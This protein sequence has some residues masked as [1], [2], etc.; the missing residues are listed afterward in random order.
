M[1][2]FL[3]SFVGANSPVLAAAASQGLHQASSHLQQLQAH[4]LRT[5]P[6]LSPQNSF[7]HAASYLPPPVALFGAAAQAAAAATS[8]SANKSDQ[9]PAKEDNNVVSSTMEEL[10]AQ[11]TNA[12][13]KEKRKGKNKGKNSIPVQEAATSSSTGFDRDDFEE[14]KDFFET[15]CHWENCDKGDFGSQDALVKVSTRFILI[16]PKM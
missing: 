16:R 4:L 5:S 14:E 10:D 8:S 2:F 12:G 7:I 3:C 13:R 1:Q 15:H 6:Y 11:E 9:D